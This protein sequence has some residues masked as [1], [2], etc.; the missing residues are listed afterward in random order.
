MFF[1]Q[2]ILDFNK[3]PILL[4]NNI[5]GGVSIHRHLLMNVQCNTLD[6]VLYLTTNSANCSQFLS[7]SP[8]FANLEL[9]LLLSEET[10][11]YT[12][13]TEV[14]LQGFSEALHS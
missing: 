3:R 10:E 14:P 5:D 6:H 9:L 2:E 4:D 13:V 7:I 8:L 1:T 11:F 12:D